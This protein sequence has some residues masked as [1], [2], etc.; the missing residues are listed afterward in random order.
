MKFDF[1]NGKWEIEVAEGYE[2]RSDEIICDEKFI[3][4]C[5]SDP[6]DKE[7]QANARLISKAPE[8]LKALIECVPY[9]CNNKTCPQ[10]S[11]DSNCHIKNK[12][13][14]IEQATGKKWEEICENL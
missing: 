1:T 8:M 9:F 2:T 10:N 6:F 7:A 13:Q 4:C 14:I 12:K 11:C 3:C 5:Q